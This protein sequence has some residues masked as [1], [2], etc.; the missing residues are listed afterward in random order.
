MAYD[1]AWC[2]RRGI[3]YIVQYL[4]P[5]LEEVYAP[6][7]QL[8]AEEEEAMMGGFCM[9]VVRVVCAGCVCAVHLYCFV[10][11]AC[12]STSKN[13]QTMAYLGSPERSFQDKLTNCI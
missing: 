3:A 13:W 1:T 9:L 4:P 10:R 6:H 8:E 11:L 7:F 2:I 5:L 12:I